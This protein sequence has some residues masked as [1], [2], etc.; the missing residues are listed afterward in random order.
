VRLSL[1]LS[2]SVL[3]AACCVAG[4]EPVNQDQSPKAAGTPMGRIIIG[5]IGDSTVAA[6]YGW[7]PAFAER[8]S[9]EV[10]VVNMAK[11]GA[12]LASLSN[13]LDKLLEKGPHYV[14][15]Q[16]GHNDMKRYDPDVYSTNLKG[17]VDRIQRSGAQPIILSSVTR[18]NFGSDRKISP[19]VMEGRSLPA[20]A[21]AAQAVASEMD[22][23]FLDLYAISIQHHNQIGPETVATY[24]Y[25]AGDKTH[26]SP[27]GAKAIAD[28]VLGELRS[29]A[30]QLASCIKGEEQAGMEPDFEVASKGTAWEPAFTDA[31]TGN[32]TNQWFLDGEIGTVETGENGMTLTAGPEFKNDAHHMVLWTKE[33]FEGDLKIE[34]DYV[35]Q[36]GENRCVNIIYIQAT[37]SGEKGFEKDISQWSDRRTVPSMRTYFNHMHAYHISYAAFGN[38]GKSKT[39]YIR[40]RRYMPPQGLRGTE[41]KPES[42][43]ESLFATGVK[44]HI[45]II[46]KDREIHMRI[47]NQDGVVYCYMANEKLPVITEGRIG[48][49]HMYTRSAT[50]KNFMVSTLPE[51]APR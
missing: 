20:F 46:K 47:E 11:N 25:N 7:G 40:G 50:Y 10:T 13:A 16:F 12:T 26:F 8:M 51:K 28:L 9:D 21:R 33:S 1:G 27:A 6:T 41:L 15:V 18:R 35:R 3:L 2:L 48:L 49:R 24:N 5:L 42:V 23:L 29:I 36:D 22:V 19:V 31:C 30:P 34:Y 45:T 43:S 14:L 37:G 39:S 44:H 38:D 32:W 17:Y 4:A